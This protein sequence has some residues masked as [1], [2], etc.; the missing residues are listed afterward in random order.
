M[1]DDQRWEAV[2]ARRPSADGTF[3]YAVRS[4]GVF[5]RPSCP[6]RKPARAR[7][8]FFATIDEAASN[9][10]RACLRCRPLELSND[11]WP[12]RIARACRV[13]ATSDA[14]FTLA[15][16]ARKVGGSAFHLQRT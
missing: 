2:L 6:S 14:R 9:G 5:C 3:V 7:V 8:L 1:T 12:E 15:S 11:G 13:L 16:L 10:F 4:T